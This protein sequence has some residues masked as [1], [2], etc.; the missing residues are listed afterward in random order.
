MKLI[1]IEGKPYEI[2]IFQESPYEPKK[3]ADYKE[4]DEN[5]IEIVTCKRKDFNSG[6]TRIYSDYKIRT[7]GYAWIEIKPLINEK[8]CI[9]L[10]K[11]GFYCNVLKHKIYL[12]DIFE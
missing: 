4:L 3:D 12:K 5:L 11:K 2:T 7:K 1:K 8:Y 6:R 10:D 9:Y